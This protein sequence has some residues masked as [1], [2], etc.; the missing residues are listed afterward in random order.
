ME[1]CDV[2]R[3]VSSNSNRP[4]YRLC[5]FRCG[6]NACRFIHTYVYTHIP[7][8]IHRSG[9]TYGFSDKVVDGMTVNINSVTVNFKS[10][11]FYASAQ[12]SFYGRR[13][14]LSFGEFHRSLI[15]FSYRGLDWKA[16]LRHGRE[17]IYNW[18][19]S[20]TPIVAKFWSSRNWIGSCSESRLNPW[21]MEQLTTS[22][23]LYAWLQIMQGVG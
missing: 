1:T 21:R 15:R 12:V 9:G 16:G 20:R 6:W 17:P 22:P 19:G 14:N 11:A 13:K 18:P 7:F 10:H 2:H 3:N 4:S 8:K 23:H 5:S